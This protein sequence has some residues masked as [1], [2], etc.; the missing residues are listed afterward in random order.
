MILVRLREA[1]GRTNLVEPTVREIFT[2][3]LDHTFEVLQVESAKVFPV[4]LRAIALG[5]ETPVPLPA[6]T[7]FRIE[8]KICEFG[9][10]HPLRGRLLLP[11]DSSHLALLAKSGIELP[12]VLR[13]FK[14]LEIGLGRRQVIRQSIRS[15]LERVLHRLV[16][17]LRGQPTLE[18]AGQSHGSREFGESCEFG[19]E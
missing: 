17:R 15:R 2:T 1:V 19:R 12:H 18:R 5:A 16:V 4:N 9:V 14:S 10:V 11:A 3:I 13:D 8:W 7:E 6:V